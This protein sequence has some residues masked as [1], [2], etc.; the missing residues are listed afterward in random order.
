MGSVAVQGST[1][2]KP[3]TPIAY[4]GK[5]VNNA[6]DLQWSNNDPRTVSYTVIKTTRTSWVS[7]ENVEINGITESKF[8]DADIKANTNYEYEVMSVDKDGIRSLPT[9]AIELSFEAK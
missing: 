5:I 8:H 3:Q 1:L 6:V 2:S 4:D 7:K 9:K